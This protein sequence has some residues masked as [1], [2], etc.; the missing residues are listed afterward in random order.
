MKRLHIL[1][2]MACLGSMAAKAQTERTIADK[3]LF[4]LR[5]DMPD[6]TVAMNPVTDF[7][8]P[9]PSVVQIGEWFYCFKTGFPIKIYRSQDLCNWTATCSLVRTLTTPLA[10][11]SSTP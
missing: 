8:C 3:A 9:D 7:D 2:L 11:A 4:E 5:K 1:L 6:K 10:M